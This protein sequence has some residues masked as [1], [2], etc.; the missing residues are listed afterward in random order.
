MRAEAQKAASDAACK[1]RRLEARLR[2]R[3]AAVAAAAL[4]VALGT[5][6]FMS[7][8]FQQS[9]GALPAASTPRRAGCMKLTLEH[10]CSNGSKAAWGPYTC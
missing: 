4:D 9:K 10:C 5:E 6:R 1:M 7:A 3:E 2:R 8:V